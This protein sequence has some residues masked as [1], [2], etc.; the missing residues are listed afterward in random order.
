MQP[1]AAGPAWRAAA[2]R[3]VLVKSAAEDRRLN[4]G[5]AQRLTPQLLE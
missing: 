4:I 1:K 2:V 5:E 3:I